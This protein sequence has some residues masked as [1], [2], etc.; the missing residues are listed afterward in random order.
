M[1]KTDHDGAFR[2][3][4]G[5][6]R[7][8]ED[9][10]K[11][12]VDSSL[13]DRLDMST[14]RQVAARHVS[15]GLV[16]SEN[17]M[18][19]EVRTREGDVAF[20]YVM[21]E[22][23]ARPD[24]TMALRMLNYVGQFYRGLAPRT[25]IRKRRSLPQVL[26]I[27]LYNGEPAWLA[28]QELNEMIERGLPGLVA[29]GIRMRYLLVDVWRSPGLDRALGNV[30]DA[31]FRLQRVGSLEG[32]KREVDL[33]KEWLA[34]EEWASLRRA[35]V[36]WIIK[37]LLP[38]RLPEAT[39]PEAEELW[40]VSVALEGGMTTWTENLKAEARAEG[41]AEGLAE[42]RIRLLVSMARKRF[43]EAPASAIA[44]LLGTVT[45]EAVLDEIG[46]WL[47]TCDSGEALLARI[48]EI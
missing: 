30:A 36:T 16:Q 3:L 42:G 18:I 9:L 5:H 29:Y 20:I 47:L 23:Q 26:P 48:H 1:P 31:L 2:L 8:V 38:S 39:L 17:D 27:A 11:G 37:V 43:G 25:E 6:P 40:E 19:W 24:W 35:F 28:A 21:V 41:L 14:L 32:G 4:F 34:G 13:A 22:F 10:L 33:L 44:T 15:E 7:V 45:S 46:T 12:F